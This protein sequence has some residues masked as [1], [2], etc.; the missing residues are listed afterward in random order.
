[1]L[2]HI[3]SD[4]ITVSVGR[5][6]SFCPLL[7]CL[8]V[9]TG[10]GSSFDVAPVDPK[11]ATDAAMEQ[12]DK[13]SD[14]FLDLE[15]LAACPALLAALGEYDLNADKK[16]SKEELGDRIEKMYGRLVKLTSVDCKVTMKNKPLRGALV[17]FVPEECL[18]SG[19]TIT[20]EGTTNQVGYTDIA[21]S[22]ERLPED[23]RR[24]R[25][26]QVGLYRVEITHPTANIPARYNANTQ[27]GFE[28]HPDTHGGSHAI[29]ELKAK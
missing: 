11:G 13:N 10:C 1:M 20:A 15:E 3:S 8:L 14:G 17:R 26:T 23:L 19:T 29:F 7:L 4:R 21:V 28:V 22:A 5:A 25:K 27:L 6:W 12:Y 18:G 2:T 24:Y 9:V 16:I